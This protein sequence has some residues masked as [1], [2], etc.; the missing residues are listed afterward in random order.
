MNSLE[1]TG[2][3][4]D[5]RP[6]EFHGLEGSGNYTFLMF[7]GCSNSKSNIFDQFSLFCVCV[8]VYRP[9]ELPA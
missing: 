2:Y 7:Y 9:E 5:P 3:S 6:W 4:L 1:V 8:C